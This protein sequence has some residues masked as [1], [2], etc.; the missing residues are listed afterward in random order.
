MTD[1]ATQQLAETRTAIRTAVDLYL[2][3]ADGIDR[4]LLAEH[5]YECLS[6]EMDRLYRIEAGQA[7]LVAEIHRLRAQLAAVR[8]ETLREAAAHTSECCA[9]RLRRLAEDAARP[10]PAA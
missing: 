8:S 9:I 10:A 5:L 1:P 3:G 4:E 2:D 6:D 7:T